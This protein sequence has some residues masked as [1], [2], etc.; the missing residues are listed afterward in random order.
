MT[1][2]KLT[3]AK[4]ADIALKQT[5]DAIYDLASQKRIVARDFKARF[6]TPQDAL[7]FVLTR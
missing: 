4:A 7:R 1:Q 5:P 3:F 6:A 2:S